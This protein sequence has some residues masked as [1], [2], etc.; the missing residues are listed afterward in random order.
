[1][2]CEWGRL[3]GGHWRC[4]NIALVQVY[5]EKKKEMN[6][7]VSEKEGEEECLLYC[8]WNFILGIED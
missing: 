8:R 3:S 5:K 4:V 1:M 2:Q 6:P 7:I